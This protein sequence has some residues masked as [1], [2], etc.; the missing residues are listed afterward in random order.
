MLILYQTSCGRN[1]HIGNHLFSFFAL[2]FSASNLKMAYSLLKAF[3]VSA[4]RTFSIPNNH[5]HNERVQGYNLPHLDLLEQP[6][7]QYPS[8]RTVSLEQPPLHS[9][10]H[11]NNHLKQINY[12]SINQTISF[13]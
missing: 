5:A 12:C 1:S 10:Q 13:T 9:Q 8:R 11:N 6:Q 3:K 4:K 7:P 2:L